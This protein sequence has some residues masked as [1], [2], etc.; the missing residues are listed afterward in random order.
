MKSVVYWSTQHQRRVPRKDIES[1]TEAWKAILNARGRHTPW[2]G[3]IYGDM[4]LN[5]DLG[6]L[7]AQWVT[8]DTAQGDARVTEPRVIIRE[9]K[10]THT[11]VQ[12]SPNWLAFE[13]DGSAELCT[14][15]RITHSII[16]RAHL[17]KQSM[18]QAA[19]GQGYGLITKA[20]SSFAH[21]RHSFQ[22]AT[23]DG[24]S[25]MIKETLDPLS[26]MREARSPATCGEMG[27]S[28]IAHLMEESIM[29]MLI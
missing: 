1:I 19:P 9:P 26:W 18:H 2:M 5:S 16:A 27:R 6:D 21:Y 25:S 22:A 13:D 12:V 28:T 11:R 17:F 7:K 24:G 20:A 10:V 14:D 29:R 3:A 23:Q 8:L 4:L 15:S